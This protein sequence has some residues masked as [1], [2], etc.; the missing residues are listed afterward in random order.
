MFVSARN[1]AKLAGQLVLTKYVIDDIAHLKTRFLYKSIEQS[2]SWDKSLG[3]CNDMVDEILFWKFD[4]VISCYNIAL[5][6]V[7]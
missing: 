2:S 4:L 1:L 3:N 6:H 7:H 5:F